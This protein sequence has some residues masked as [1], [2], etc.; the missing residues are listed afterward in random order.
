MTA[1]DAL[2]ERVAA[3]DPLTDDDAR[4]VLGTQ[5]LIAIGMLGDEVRRRLHGRRT[6]FVRVFEIHADAVP[7]AFPPAL[8]AGEIRLVGRPASGDAAVRA[9]KAAARLEAHVP[10]T[11]F[12]L[13]E[14]EALAPGAAFSGFAADLKSAGLDAIADVFVDAPGDPA[15][16]VIAARDAGLLVQR[17]S[18]RYPAPANPVAPIARARDL[19][20]ALAGFAAY[21]PLPRDVSV[22]TPTTGYDDV[23]HVAL[24]RLMLSTIPSIQ[25]DWRGYGPKLAQVA[26]TMGADDVDGVSG[27]GPGALGTRRSPLEE[28]RGNIKAAALEPAERDGRFQP[29]MTR[30]EETGS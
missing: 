26:L 20:A 28:I 19:Q 12:S 2:S 30:M 14:L 27:E 9:V 25:V 4:L 1:L 17:L 23:K 8:D 29:R 3:G 15:P 7:A 5:D 13:D 24:S 21:A 6:T 16:G 10:L 11:G 18:V 22:A